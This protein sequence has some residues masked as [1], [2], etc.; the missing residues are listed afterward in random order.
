MRKEK[1]NL[2]PGYVASKESRLRRIGLRAIPELVGAYGL[3][4]ISLRQYDLM[5]RLGAVEQR[6]RL[7]GLER[8]SNCVRL[9]A[10][11]IEGMLEGGSAVELR[12]VRRAIREELAATRGSIGS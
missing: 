4:E 12:E 11:V 3:G 7:A 10:E 2:R 9:A 5:S 6:A 1:D 8:E